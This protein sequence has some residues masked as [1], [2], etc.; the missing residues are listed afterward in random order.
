MSTRT[1]P[2]PRYLTIRIRLGTRAAVERAIEAARVR[3]L[4]A[5]SRGGRRAARERPLQAW[6]TFRAIWLACGCHTANVDSLRKIQ[7]AYREGGHGLPEGLSYDPDGKFDRR[8][9]ALRNL[10]RW[11]KKS[12]ARRRR[13]RTESGAELSPGPSSDGRPT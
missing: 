9:S 11:V 4:Q 13:A 10:Q 7:T 2:K 8:D 5:I 6:T 12:G 1:Q 3:A